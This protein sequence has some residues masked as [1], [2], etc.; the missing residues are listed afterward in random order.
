MQ[1]NKTPVLAKKNMQLIM[2][3]ASKNWAPTYTAPG[4]SDVIEFLMALWPV[5]STAH[6]QLGICRNPGFTAAWHDLSESGITAAVAQA[7]QWETDVY[8]HC[9]AHDA[10]LTNARGNNDSATQLCCL[11]AD[12][13]LAEAEKDNGKNY[14]TQQFA[15]NMLNSL[16]V[17][18]SCVINSGNGLHAY[19]LFTELVDAQSHSRLP[20]AFQSYLHQQL[21]DKDTGEVYDIDATHELARILRLPGT[22]N[23]KGGRTV[24]VLSLDKNLRYSVDELARLCPAV[25][26]LQKKRAQHTVIGIDVNPDAEPPKNKLE[27]LMRNPKFAD[28][29]K[30]CRTDLDQKSQS[31]YDMSLASQA[32]RAGWTDQETTDLMIAHRREHN[33]EKK[34][35][36]DY[37]KRTIKKAKESIEDYDA[38]EM[39]LIDEFNQKHAVV[40]AGKTLILSER[41]DPVFNRVTFDLETKQ[42]HQDWYANRMFRGKLVS[43]IWFKS[44]KRRQYEGIVFSPGKNVPDYYNMFRGF[45]VKPHEGDCS[46]YLNLM[47]EVICN[48]NEEHYTYVL[49]WLA[50]M[51]QRPDELPGV[52]LVLRG[53]QGIGKGTLMKYLGKLVGQHFLELVK[54]RQVTGNFNAHM[55]DT[56]LLHAN[57]AIWGGDKSAEGAIKAMITDETSAIEFKGKDIIQVMNYMRLVFSSNNVWVVA[58]DMDDRRFFILDVSDVHKEDQEYFG[59]IKKQMEAGGLE[60]LMH[61]LLNVD[62]DGFNPRVRPQSDGAGFD[63]KL[64]SMDS[65]SQWLYELLDDG[66]LQRSFVN[67]G[68]ISEPWPSVY[69]KQQLHERYMTWC[70]N[71]HI[72]HPEIRATFCKALNKILPDLPSTKKAWGD[73]RQNCYR[74]PSL[75]KCRHLFEQACKEGPSIWSQQENDS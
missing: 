32:V 23:S 43:N 55:K 66:E 38:E 69:P 7:L 34:L 73:K 2:P 67:D 64:K 35:R 19:W 17:P 61:Y 51:F 4:H 47:K 50:H 14:P 54:M 10:S 63:M 75:E 65:V 12:I 22:K 36:S 42:S 62:L 71:Q 52:A 28:T 44:A 72:R 46:L 68:A 16:P 5:N 74:L 18:P 8:F 15:L 24:E 27:E 57:E 48:G 33:E 59:A 6:G 40:R 53:R 56:L 31:E 9:A 13:D 60:A 30:R 41:Y 25:H 49:K 26:T 20:E 39:A 21:V 37:Y 1:I 58:I 11:W 70:Q 45:P 3:A 29:W